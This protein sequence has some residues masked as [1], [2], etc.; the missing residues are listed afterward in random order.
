[1]FHHLSAPSP[2]ARQKVSTAEPWKAASPN[3][4]L[5]HPDTLVWVNNLATLLEKQGKLEEAGPRS[6]GYQ[7]VADR[8]AFL[9]WRRETGECFLVSHKLR[10]V[11]DSLFVVAVGSSLVLH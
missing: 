10:T 3:W 8:K 1:M 2:A 7:E 11:Y 9:M 4:E 6:L 5:Q